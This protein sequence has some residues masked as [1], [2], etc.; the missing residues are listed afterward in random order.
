MSKLLW[1]AQS[2][3]LQKPLMKPWV[4]VVDALGEVGRVPYSVGPKTGFNTFEY[5]LSRFLD[6]L[7]RFDPG[8]PSLLSRPLDRNLLCR[9]PTQPIFNTGSADFWAEKS[10][11]QPAFGGSFIYPL[12]L[13]SSFTSTP[14]MNSWMTNS[15]T[16]AFIS[17]STP[18][19]HL[20]QS[21][22]GPFMWGEVCWTHWWFH[23]LIHSLSLPLLS[24]LQT[25]ILCGFVT[26]GTL[27]SLTDRGFL[28]VSK[29]VDDP[30]KF[31]LPALLS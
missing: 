12:P 25:W 9:K 21:F 2:I 7:S 24:S 6:R 29:F 16:S 10:N 13:L 5:W 26:L 4:L 17:S 8:P 3:S 30:K 22:G 20:L 31:V 19:S 15:Q 1:W 27:C 11:G 28:R 23:H 18:K 14:S